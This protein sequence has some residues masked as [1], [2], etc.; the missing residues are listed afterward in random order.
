MIKLKAKRIRCSRA[1]SLKVGSGSAL[2]LARNR[3]CV[4]WIGGVAFVTTVLLPAV[5]DLKIA[6]VTRFLLA[7][8]FT[9]GYVVLV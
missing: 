4:L 8:V 7:I 1:T 3:R 9:A 6:E 2:A 5:R